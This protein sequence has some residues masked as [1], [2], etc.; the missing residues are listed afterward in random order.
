M[1]I[2]RTEYTAGSGSKIS[3]N[4]VKGPACL[5]LTEELLK[6]KGKVISQT[7]TDEMHETPGVLANN[8]VDQTN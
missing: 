4:G 3:V 2:I 5:K 8:T 6:E 7:P 1:A